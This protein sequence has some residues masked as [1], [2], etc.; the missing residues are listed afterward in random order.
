MRRYNKPFIVAA[1]KVDKFIREKPDEEAI[2]RIYDIAE[3][4]EKHV[5]SNCNKGDDNE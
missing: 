1:D 3:K 2:N 5:K 4:F